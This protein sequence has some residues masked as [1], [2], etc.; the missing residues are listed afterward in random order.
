MGTFFERGPSRGGEE[1]GNIKKESTLYI[2]HVG[3]LHMG[4]LM[5]CRVR[6]IH[7]AK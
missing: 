4:V 7:E 5:H 1:G 2:G 6:E 3:V